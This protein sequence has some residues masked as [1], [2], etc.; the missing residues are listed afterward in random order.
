MKDLQPLE[1]DYQNKNLEDRLIEQIEYE[2]NYRLMY[3]KQLKRKKKDLSLKELKYDHLMNFL[4][5]T[6]PENYDYIQ[7][8]VPEIV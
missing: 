1:I 5:E 8:V 4:T 6:I 3:M 7:K 2:A